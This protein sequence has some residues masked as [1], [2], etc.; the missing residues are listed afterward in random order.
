MNHHLKGLVTFG[1]QNVTRVRIAAL[2]VFI[3]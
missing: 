2:L 3:G 1:R